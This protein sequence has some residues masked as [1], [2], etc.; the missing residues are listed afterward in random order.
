MTHF[1][2]VEM[3]HIDMKEVKKYGAGPIQIKV[4]QDDVIQAQI[5]A[6]LYNI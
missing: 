2:S 1:Y 6:W 4:I 5:I 3:I